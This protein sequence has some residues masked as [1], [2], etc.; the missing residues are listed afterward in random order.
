MNKQIL[1]LFIF[2]KDN[3]FHLFS[4]NSKANKSFIN[5]FYILN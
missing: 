5:I 1:I 2:L 3:D 4:F